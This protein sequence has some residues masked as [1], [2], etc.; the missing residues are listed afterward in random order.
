MCVTSL[1]FS[2]YP[3]AVPPPCT[4]LEQVGNFIR[5]TALARHMRLRKSKDGG[6]SGDCLTDEILAQF[7]LNERQW[8]QGKPG[9]N[10]TDHQMGGLRPICTMS[11]G[12][13][14]TSCMAEERTRHEP[15][16]PA[17]CELKRGS[18]TGDKLDINWPNRTFRCSFTGASQFAIRQ[19]TCSMESVAQE[20]PPYG[21]GKLIAFP[22]CSFHQELM[23]VIRPVGPVGPPAPLPS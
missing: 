16:K 21:D 15:E 2:R 1:F 6:I 23:A 22:I 10:L 11:D 9:L 8:W 5:Q 13:N 20:I 7:P 4:G 12:K 3:L 17:R 19:K 14:E 18:R